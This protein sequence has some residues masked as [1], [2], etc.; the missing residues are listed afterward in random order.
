VTLV[1]SPG[2]TQW[3]PAAITTALWLDA[4]DASTITTVSGA[5]SQWNDKSGNARNFSQTTADSRPSYTAS[6]INGR[7]VARFDGTNDV[8]NGDDFLGGSNYVSFIG[9]VAIRTVATL[10][11]I[12]SVTKL[13]GGTEFAMYLLRTDGSSRYS[14]GGRRL[15]ADTLAESFQSETATTAVTLIEGIHDY[16]NS[17]QFL[18]IN[19]SATT[20][21]TSFQTAGSLDTGL[22]TIGIGAQFDGS[23]AIAVDIGELLC[24]TTSPGTTNHQKLEGYLAHKWGLTASL[25]SDHPYKVNPPAP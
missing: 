24:L 2:F 13:S 15:L 21:N 25:P 16:A 10:R 4:A 9:V 22:S 6:I 5:V 18:R 19:G 23:G 11:R 7:A 14:V 17:D 20:S 1:W 8:L 3:D 12:V